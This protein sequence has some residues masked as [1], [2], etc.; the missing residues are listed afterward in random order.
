MEGSRYVLVIHHTLK[1]G[2]LHKM[3]T[4]FLKTDVAVK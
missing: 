2:V 1:L 3:K 4:S